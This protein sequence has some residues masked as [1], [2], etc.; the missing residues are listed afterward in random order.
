[1]F[2]GDDDGWISG[3]NSKYPDAVFLKSHA[4]LLL[5]LISDSLVC[6]V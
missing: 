5:S 4:I 3:Y 1:M 6:V 2:D